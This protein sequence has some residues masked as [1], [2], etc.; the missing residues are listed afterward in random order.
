MA[1]T[2]VDMS[3]VELMPKWKRGNATAG[4][5]LRELALTADKY[6]ERFEK[7][8]VVYSRLDEEGR[9]YINYGN[10][11]VNTM[12]LLGLLRLAEVEILRVTTS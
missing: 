11:G 4:D 8:F 9:N 12:E 1:T 5:R 2:K 6:P 10:F 3:N 7:L